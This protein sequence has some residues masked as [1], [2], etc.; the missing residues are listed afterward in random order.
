M[1]N[2][3][4]KNVFSAP[5]DPE[6][7]RFLQLPILVQDEVRLLMKRRRTF[8]AVRLIRKHTAYNRREA[9]DI[10]IALQIGYYVPALPGEEEG[11]D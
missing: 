4:L 1:A 7:A 5:L 11:R 3:F 10:A 2:K 8:A 6:R 9:M